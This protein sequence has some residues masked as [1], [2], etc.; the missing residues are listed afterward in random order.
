MS[1]RATCDEG[2]PAVEQLWAP[3]LLCSVHERC[4]QKALVWLSHSLLFHLSCLPSFFCFWGWCWWIGKGNIELKSN[5]RQLVLLKRYA[6]L[7][8]IGSIH[9][10]PWKELQ[11][12]VILS[13]KAFSFWVDFNVR[14]AHFCMLLRKKICFCMDHLVLAQKEVSMVC[15][16]SECAVVWVHD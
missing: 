10:C 2:I 14:S 5:M 11:G 15:L 9:F 1:F 7:V 3:S 8:R 13:W 16:E 12:K 4:T 6:E